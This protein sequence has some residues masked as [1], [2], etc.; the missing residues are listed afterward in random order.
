MPITER[1][2]A[3]FFEERVER[4]QAVGPTR[5]VIYQDNHPDLAERRDEA[6]RARLAPLLA[7]DGSQ[8]LLDVGCGTGRW[9]ETLRPRVRDYHGID[10]TEGLIAYARKRF[11]TWSNVRFSVTQAD[12][13]TLESLGEPAP[14]DRVLSAGLL[15][16]L[17]DDAM[18]RAL[19]CMRAATGEGGSLLL[20]R[21]PVAQG[22]RLTIQ[23]H[24]SEDL[25]ASYNAIY[26][27]RDELLDVFDRVFRQAGLRVVDQGK[28]FDEPEL[29]NR[30]ETQ[31]EWFLV[32]DKV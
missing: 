30:A 6:E 20:F 21:E 26:R 15:I 7:L 12:D 2:V 4:I 13:F 18:E 1:S 24:F 32:G 14:F 16:Y 19:R 27:T 5:A 10:L 17:N 22:E 29:S 28:V 11:V 9:V 23:D 8:R 3:A 25:N 31:Q